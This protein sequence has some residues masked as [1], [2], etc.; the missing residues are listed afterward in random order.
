MTHTQRSV[1]LTLH[2]NPQWV[3]V[4]RIRLFVALVELSGTRFVNPLCGGHLRPD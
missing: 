1:M 3:S 4:E 2:E